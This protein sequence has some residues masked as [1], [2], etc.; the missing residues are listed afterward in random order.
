M[1]LLALV[2][3]YPY[4]PNAN[5]SAIL[6]VLDD[7]HIAFLPILFNNPSLIILSQVIL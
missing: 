5:L 4:M 2:H 3:N 1:F 7:T 6:F